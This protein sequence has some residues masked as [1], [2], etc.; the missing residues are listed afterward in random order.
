MPKAPPKHGSRAGYN[1]ELISTGEPCDR[2]RAANRVYQR[3]YTK[4]GR[5]KGIKYSA[6]QVIDHLDNPTKTVSS[7]TH[8]SPRQVLDSSQDSERLSETPATL[9]PDP[10]EVGSE[11]PLGSRLGQALSDGLNRLH[12]PTG[13]AY[14]EV[15]DIPDYLQDAATSTPKD[16]EPSGDWSPVNEAPII[17]R[18][19]MAL[20][21]ENMGTYLS[22]VGMTLELVDPYCGPIA[23]QNLDNMVKR[24][25]KVVS[26]YPSAARLFMAKGG[27]VIMDW[28][29]ALQATWPLL[30]ALY[31]HHL[32]K[33]V[34]T[35]KGQV[36][37]LSPNGNQPNVDATTPPMGEYEYT[38]R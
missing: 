22:V 36:Y 1:A 27:G 21:E 23:E 6:N 38:A 15:E 3:Q 12:L 26:R 29:G 16:E 34:K 30:L 31:E 4:A 37:R 2:C 19:T 9:A 18:Q 8:N 17:T 5:A 32:A 25:S 13:D 20:I 28:I 10:T 7:T 35:D 11:Q 24:W 33:T 14:V